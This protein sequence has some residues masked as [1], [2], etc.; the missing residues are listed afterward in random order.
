MNVGLFSG[1]FGGIYVSKEHRTL[2]GSVV[3]EEIESFGL[4]LSGY[5][6]ICEAL[7]GHRRH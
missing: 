6:T 5:M 1:V 7:S 4:K 3:P 2:V